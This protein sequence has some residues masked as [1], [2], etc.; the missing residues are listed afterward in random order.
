MIP[1]LNT[2]VGFLGRD[3][4]YW[5]IGQIEKR[6]TAKKAF[7]YKVRIVGQ[8]VMSCADVAPDDLPWA[9]V[10]YP[11]TAPSREGNSNHTP[12]KLDKGDWVIGFFMD[13]QTGQQ[14]MILGALHKVV[15]STSNPSFA[16]NS[17]GDSCLAFKRSF[18]TTNPYVAQAKGA[19]DPATP[20]ASTP[21]APG[22]SSQIVA[23]SSGENS[24]TNPSGRNHCVILP[25]AGCKDPKK[26]QSDFERVLSE[27]FLST[28]NNGGQVGTQILSDVTG[29]LVDYANAANGYVTRI[30]GLARAYIGAAKAELFK[31]IKAGISSLL[32]ICLGIPTP[33]PPDGTGSKS[34]PQTSSKTGILGQLTTFLNDLLGQI[35]CQIADLEDAILNFLTNLIFG[36]LEN[37]INGATCIVESIVSQVLSELETFLSETI[38]TILGILQSIL[39]IVA[40]PLNILSAALQYIFQL[41]GISCSGPSNECLSEEERTYCTGKQKKKPGEDDFAALDSLIAGI[42]SNGVTPLQTACESALANPCPEATT[43][44]VIGGTPITTPPTTSTVVL[45]QVVISANPQTVPYNGSTT[46]TWTSTNATSVVS[47]NFG[48]TSTSGTL[49]VTNLTSD[50]TYEITVDGSDG[51]GGTWNTS[52]N[53]VVF[54]GIQASTPP[55]APAPL[56]PTAA[57][58]VGVVSSVVG[59]IVVSGNSLVTSAVGTIDTIT[60]NSIVYLGISGS[61]GNNNSFVA[62]AATSIANGTSTIP[63]SSVQLQYS[64]TTNKTLVTVSDTV[65]FTFSVVNGSVADGTVFDYFIFGS[66][67]VNDFAAKTVTGSMTM[68]NNVAVVDI[69][70]SDSF[71][72]YG[73]KPMSFIVLQSGSSLASVGFNL[74]NPSTTIPQS[75]ITPKVVKPVLC[76]VEVDSSGKIMSVGI[77]GT[78]TPYATKPIIKIAGEGI[79]ASVVPVLD[80]KGYLVKAKVLRPGTGYVP[81]RYNRNCIIDG[82]II[83]RPGVGYTEPPTIYVDGDDTIARAIVD[84]NGYL[85]DVEVLNKTKT[86]DTFP[87][88]QI[89]GVG[90]GAKAIPSLGCLDEDSYVKYVSSVAPAGTDSVVD[91]P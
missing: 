70:T 90:M 64:L 16:P 47:S 36:L 15:G 72:F 6:D 32:K 5:W 21:E 19:A 67:Q 56:V 58:P 71:S 34:Q 46:I 12:V 26:K 39:T 41:F 63:A 45:P 81:T 83:I 89:L 43:A 30:F 33:T 51:Q 65:R 73:T 37:I 61:S 82:F 87:N 24:K 38:S 85:V 74:N 31:Q 77:C 14:P 11:V 42:A 84:S 4:F 53:T 17:Y 76:N 9:N 44:Y 60:A 57:A 18:A 2:P 25:D 55:A 28:Q 80:S 8:H 29:T 86:F 50:T 88:I 20:L 22:K 3:G 75:S 91:C 40:S 52:A 49:N 68:N 78:G 59:N 13:G 27:F 69:Q 10:V 48:A 66:V 7:R 54:V 1:E 79:G 23:E 35:N 62:T